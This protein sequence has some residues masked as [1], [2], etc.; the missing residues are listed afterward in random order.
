MSE[1]WLIFVLVGAAGGFTAGLFGVG[2]GL[3][4]VPTLYLLWRHDPVLGPEVM[5]FAVATSLACIVVTSVSSSWTH[6]RARRLHYPPLPWMVLAVSLGAA[7]AVL[8]ASHIPTAWLKLGFG[9][10]AA[11]TCVALVRN[12][13]RASGGTSPRRRELVGIGTVIGHVSTLLGVSGGAMT[14]P[15]LILRGVDVRQAVVVSSALAIPISVVGAAGLALAGPGTTA[16]TLGYVHMPAFAG[17]SAVSLVFANWGARLSQ[18]MDQ[19]RLK[20]AFAGFLALVALHM[21]VF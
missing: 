3:V 18:T 21:L 6:W 8:L 1:L 7:S 14:V 5:H 15:Y 9:L 19:R 16:F 10:F 2:G 17:I 12:R 13:N 4:I 11:A 20:L